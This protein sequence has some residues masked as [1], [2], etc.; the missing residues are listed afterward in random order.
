MVVNGMISKNIKVLE[1]NKDFVEL[2]I[3][4]NPE[5]AGGK[6]TWMR[7]KTSRRN[8]DE[9]NSNLTLF[10]KVIVSYQVQKV[11]FMDYCCIDNI[12]VIKNYNGIL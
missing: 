10:T 7:F 5:Q 1:K 6:T 3:P 9:L 8:Y 4:V 11:D 12:N 2:L